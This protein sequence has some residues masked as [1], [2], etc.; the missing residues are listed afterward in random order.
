MTQNKKINYMRDIK[1]R[2]WD[3][4]CKEMFPNVHNH[5][6]DKEWAFGSMLKDD[7]W[8]IMQYT[9]LK[10]KNGTEVYEGDIVKTDSG[11]NQKVCYREDMARFVLRF[12]EGASTDLTKDCEIIGNIYQHPELI[13]QK[14]LLNS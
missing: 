4:T 9:G 10:D 13:Q 14:N 6:N 11:A 2:A 7:R 5:I 8:S 1:F 3:T 12:N